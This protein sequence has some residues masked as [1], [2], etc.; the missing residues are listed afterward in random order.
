MPYIANPNAGPQQTW[1][2]NDPL[3]TFITNSTTWANDLKSM[4]D[5]LAAAVETPNFTVSWGDITGSVPLS[6]GA[7]YEGVSRTED[8]VIPDLADAPT[9]PDAPVMGT[10]PSI[11]APTI[12]AAPTWDATLPDEPGDAPVV[13]I[14]SVTELNALTLPEFTVTVP[15]AT[16]DALTAPFS[17]TSGTYTPTLKD[18]VST[19][20]G[21][22]LGG[23]PIIGATAFDDIFT[24]AADDVTEMFTGDVLQAGNIC[25]MLGELPS[26]ALIVRLD[27]V[28]AKHRQGVAKVRINAAIKRA[29]MQREDLWK[30]VDAAQAFETLW[31][32]FFLQQEATKLK[33]ASA[34]VEAATAVYNANVARWNAMLAMAQTHVAVSAEYRARVMVKIEEHKERLAQRLSDIQ[35]ADIQVKAWLGQWDGFAKAAGAY[36]QV[37][38][39]KVQ[40]YSAE[41]E[42]KKAVLTADIETAKAAIEKETA[43]T[44]RF[45]EVWKG[46]ATKTQAVL[47]QMQASVVPIETWI[48]SEDTRKRSEGQTLTLA[49]ENAKN[50]LTKGVETAKLR[51]SQ[52][53]YASTQAIEVNKAIASL[54]AHTMGAYLAA[55]SVHYSVSSSESYSNS[56]SYTMTKDETA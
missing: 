19:I 52:V 7:P 53:Q 38:A 14:L 54:M 10:I 43:I 21:S 34:A 40:A 26:E 1:A 28:T 4:M 20:L 45:S 33:V 5:T 9:G 55:G 42:G 31:S 2:S 25:G 44:Q 49:L 47:T 37:L 17:F 30:G 46:I 15:S 29:E 41:I 35:A 3:Q 56:N 11:T 22:V 18:G 23:N 12:G 50:E 32:G 39:G 24:E 8:L 13:D 48:K 27:Q 51:L 6:W 36:T 16:I